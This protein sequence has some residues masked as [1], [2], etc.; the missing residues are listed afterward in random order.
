MKRVRKG[1]V[2]VGWYYWVMPMLAMLFCPPVYGDEHELLIAANGKSEYQILVPEQAPESVTEAAGELQR[3]LL[4]ASGVEL[5]ITASVEPGIKYLSIG[6]TPLMLDVE[7]GSFAH[8]AFAILAKAQHLLLVGR[9][10][11]V[12]ASASGFSGEI[13]PDAALGFYNV[14]RWNRSLSAGSY[15]AVI[16]FAR[17]FL[18]ARWYMPGPLGE[19]V[20]T[21]ERLAVAADFELRVAPHFAMRRFNFTDYSERDMRLALSGGESKIDTGI[22]QASARWGRR[23]RHTNPVVLGNGHGWRQW[24]PADQY[25]APWIAEAIGMPLYGKDHPEYFALVDGRRQS[26]YTSKAQHGGQLCVAYPPLIQ[27]YADNILALA[28]KQPGTRMFSLA[29]NDGGQHCQCDLCCAWDPPAAGWG[30]GDVESPFLTDRMLRFQNAVVEKVT[31][32]VPDARFTVAAYHATGRAPLE[33][34]ADSRLQI[35]GYYNYLPYRYHIEAK[36]RELENALEGWDR[37]TDNFYFSTFYFAYG[38]YALPWSSVETLAWMVDLM[39]RHGHQGLSMYFGAG[40]SNPLVGQLGP[41]IW[42]TSQLL[43]DPRQSATALEEEW[44]L[45]SFG[46]EAGPLVREYFAVIA[47]AMAQE[48][49]RFPGFWGSRG[50]S[51]RQI[52]LNVYPA[53]RQRCRLLLD[54]AVKAVA[55][56]DKRY[57]WRVDQ[58]A[59]NWRYVE[60]TLDAVEA[61]RQSRIVGSDQALE[62]ALV[63]GRKRQ[64]YIDD[65]ANRM[66]VSAASIR[67][68]EQQTA[69]DILTELPGGRLLTLRVPLDTGTV[70]LIDGNLDDP[71]WE[72]AAAIDTLRH[73]RTLET[74]PV[75]TAVRVLSTQEGL[76]VR[77]L[78]AE[79]DMD[80]LVLVDKAE[81]VW[82]GDVFE[83]FLAPAGGD[84]GFYQFLVNAHGTGSA[85]AHRGDTG[86]DRNWQPQWQRAGAKRADG[87]GVE[88][89]VPWEA[90][91]TDEGPAVGQQWRAGFYRE[92][93]AQNRVNSAWAPTGGIFAQPHLFGKLV[94]V[95]P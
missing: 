40:D 5:P 8:D 44:Y 13:G 64:D 53:V 89:F 88:I 22:V 93:H 60:L 68:S 1:S 50:F 28:A 79:P 70:P 43:W 48:T 38:N 47:A 95:E 65:P 46:P 84:G 39:A 91:D 45:G 17:R 18:R 56:G 3:L 76:Y 24:I 58:I 34:V 9:D 15:N 85:L 31:A 32:K 78:C 57:R 36:R 26:A 35:I 42:I 72:R 16:E 19:E 27:T 80:G 12:D 90:I 75:G 51:Q 6:A 14:R 77:A 55:D 61:V 83:V 74:A 82:R 67:V 25:S 62:A 69:L 23:L 81:E 11:G 2:G 49:A 10:E 37:A 86:M 20:G 29:Q 92:R 66:A 4:M 54:G 63:L 52:N 33:Q 71:A 94:F 73:N 59:R 30:G 87:W 41:D 21:V 7:K